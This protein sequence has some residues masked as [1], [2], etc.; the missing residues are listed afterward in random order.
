MS[1]FDTTPIGRIVNRF[2]KDMY[3]VDEQLVAT[4]MSYLATMA[5]VISVV[6]VISFATPL[7]LAFLLPLFVFYASEQNFF[8]KSY[9]ELKRLDSIARSPLYST[10]GETL[11]GIA[12]IRAFS[13]S[14]VLMNKYFD[15]LDK[16]QNAYFL[17]FAGQVSDR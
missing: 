1:F 9:R 16:Q 15:F 10:L 8:T 4:M 17:T 11:D 3:T 6:V 12:T 14:H 5:S 13:M 2:S 7:F